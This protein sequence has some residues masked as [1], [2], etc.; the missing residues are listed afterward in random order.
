MACFGKDR[1][2][3]KGKNRMDLHQCDENNS[4]K[5][6]KWKEQPIEFACSLY[7]GTA[8]YPSDVVSYQDLELHFGHD[9]NV[10]MCRNMLR[11]VQRKKTEVKMKS[12]STNTP[13]HIKK[14]LLFQTPE[15]ILP[16]PPHV[17]Q[18]M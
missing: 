13:A 7:I 17:V 14:T 10:F 6:I 4:L 5:K 12:T 1:N 15:P 18:G 3:L 8:S 11:R 16:P 2:Y 9:E